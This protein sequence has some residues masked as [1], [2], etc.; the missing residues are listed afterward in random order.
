MLDGSG[1]A[2]LRRWARHPA[3]FHLLMLLALNLMLVCI[4]LLR[5]VRTSPSTHASSSLDRIVAA[6]ELRVGCPANYAPF[7]LRQCAHADIVGSDV[8]EMASLAASLGARLEWVEVEWAELGASEAGSRF[9]IAVG[10]IDDTL[11]RRRH[12]SFSQPTRA[13]EGKVAVARCGSSTLRMLAP[14]AGE[15]ANLSAL[16]DARVRVATNR[17]GTNEALVRS[18]FV[19][20]AIVVVEAN[21]EQFGRVLR[22]EVELTVT[23]LAEARMM[24]A[25]HQGRLCY[26][27]LLTRSH[28][29]YLLPRDDFMWK[30]YVDAWLSNRLSSG[31]ASSNF[32]QWLSWFANKLEDNAT[33]APDGRP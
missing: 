2:S 18:T 15:A 3:P 26:T 7:A 29:A 24:A 19:Q 21:G 6:R 28:K 23:D 16:D 20:A 27:E 32:E 1:C 31:A 17:G 9:D 13:A 14:A 25:R 10:G 8:D 11:S 22:G 4:A 33:C 5:T 30:E 12:A